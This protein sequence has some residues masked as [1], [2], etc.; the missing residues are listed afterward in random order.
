[1]TKKLTKEELKEA[2]NDSWIYI[3]LLSTLVILTESLKTY[4]FTLSTSLT[5]SIFLVPIIY[6]LTNYITKKYGFKRSILAIAISA[7]AM[8][9][10]VAIM[11]F[12]I[13]STFDFA[14]ISGQVLGYVVSQL[15]NICIYTFLLNNTTSPWPLV[16]MNYVFCLIV[17]YMVY[18]IIQVDMIIMSK[19]WKGY[20]ITLLIQLVE[21]AI[22]TIFDKKIKKGL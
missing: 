3:M 2:Y 15:V 9:L 12:A 21:C 22:L 13:G 19:F 10:F 8:V 7:I 1:M 4:T 6:F 11:Y 20:F 16:L 14:T 18:T 17:F 5:Y